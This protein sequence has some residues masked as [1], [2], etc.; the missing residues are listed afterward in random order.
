MGGVLAAHRSMNRYF[1]LFGT[2]TLPGS[3]I[4]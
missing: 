3:G 1:F 4:S 2:V